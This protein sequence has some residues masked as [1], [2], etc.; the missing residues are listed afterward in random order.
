MNSKNLKPRRRK[1][2]I[3]GY[4]ETLGKVADTLYCKP[5][6]S[7]EEGRSLRIRLEAA[8]ILMQEM[9]N[10]NLADVPTNAQEFLDALVN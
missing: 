7:N 2:T 9:R 5:K 4:D 1:G 8:K 6:L 10:S 3:P